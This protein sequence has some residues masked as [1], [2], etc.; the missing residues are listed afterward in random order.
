MIRFNPKRV[1]AFCGAT[2]FLVLLFA[3]ELIVGAGLIPGANA[4]VDKRTHMLE[5]LAARRTTIEGQFVDNNGNAITRAEEP[6]IPGVLLYDEAYSHLIGYN[7]NMYGTSGLRKLLYK[8]LYYGGKD[9]M[10]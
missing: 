1:A 10:S 2:T 7:T 6:G 3:Y 8:D 4:A 9:G 5:D